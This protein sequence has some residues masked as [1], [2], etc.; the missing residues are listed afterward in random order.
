MPQSLNEYRPSRRWL[1]VAG[2]ILSLLAIV[3]VVERFIAYRESIDLARYDAGH[4]TVLALLAAGYGAAGVLLAAGWH[5]ILLHLGLKVRFR[6]SLRAYGLSQLIKY[7]P[8]NI[9]HLAGRQALGMAAGLPAGTLVRSTLWDLGLIAIMALAFIPLALTHAGLH[10]VAGTVAGMVIAAGL[11]AM[12]RLGG[13]SM[14]ARAALAYLVFLAVSGLLFMLLV[15]GFCSIC[16]IS[17][18]P[19]VLTLAGAYVI[20]WLAGLVTPGAPA[21]LGV[22]E[23]VLYALLSG[24][25]DQATIIELVILG[26]IVTLGGDGLFFLACLALGRRT[27]PCRDTTT[28]IQSD[29][30]SGES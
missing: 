27:G 10:P 26:R 19:V 4:W 25:V 23:V 16:D 20:A 17:A 13:G 3:F 1:N 2:G 22:R 8:G 18:P 12:A 5:N 14:L 7:I 30:R 6:W 21:G 15:T 9:F 28:K 11:L 24:S 29:D